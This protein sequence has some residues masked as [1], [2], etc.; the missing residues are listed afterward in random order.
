MDI[1][2]FAQTLFYLTFSFVIIV[3]GILFILIVYNLLKLI[4]YL[5]HISQ[6]IENASVE[7][8]DN[9]IAIIERISELPL[10]SF[11]IKHHA[12]KGRKK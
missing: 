7:I 9:V 4:S 11:F 6:N 2:Y 1:L 12:K 8:R 10:F 5:K 3:I